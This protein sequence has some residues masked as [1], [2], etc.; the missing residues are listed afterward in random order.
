MTSLPYDVFI[1]YSHRE[2]DKT[3][4]R[5][6]LVPHL[7]AKGLRVCIDFRDFQLGAPLVLEMTR[8]VEQS[9]YTLAVLS[10]AYLSSNFTEIENILAEHLGLEQSQQRLLTI[11][12]QQC[13][14]RLGIRARLMLDMADDNMFNT[15][16]IRLVNQIRELPAK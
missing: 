12:R 16:I 8:A 14:P 13:T 7:E 15:N 11:L 4:V 6:Q 10:P 3:W 1:S 5:D 2:P 9:R